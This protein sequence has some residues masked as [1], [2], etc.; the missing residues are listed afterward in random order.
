MPD[1]GNSPAP[2]DNRHRPNRPELID[3]VLDLFF[4][5]ISEWR[6]IALL[7][8]TGHQPFKRHRID[9]WGGLRF[10]HQRPQNSPLLCGQWFPLRIRSGGGGL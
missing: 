4:C 5:V 8:A 1:F 6:S 7:I 2:L 3:N 10:F 9:I